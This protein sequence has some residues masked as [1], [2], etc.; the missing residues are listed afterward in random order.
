MNPNPPAKITLRHLHPY[1]VKVREYPVNGE[2]LKMVQIKGGP[3]QMGDEYGDLWKAC[4]PKHEVNVPDFELGQILV[5]QGLWRAVMGTDP[6]HLAFREDNRPVEG[7]SWDDIVKGTKEQAAFLDQLNAIEE[8][9]QRNTTQRKRFR[10]PTEAQ[11]EYAA[12]GGRFAVFHTNKYGGSNH[13][14]EVAWYDDNSHSST[15]AVGRKRPNAQGLYD[16]SGNVYE[17][18]ADAWSDNYDQ[19][20]RDGSAYEEKEQT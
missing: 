14:R 5:T 9:K 12:R 2:V 7:V 18:C 19:A 3:F 1:C 16:M 20:P 13:L 8:I 6:S 15:V 17:W 11:W 10:L 4:R